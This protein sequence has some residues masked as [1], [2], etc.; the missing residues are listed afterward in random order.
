MKKSDI[1]SRF[2]EMNKTDPKYLKD[3]ILSFIIAGKDTTA[4][5]LSWFFYMMCKHPFLQE[6]IAEEVSKATGINQNS[7]IDELVN[8]INDDALDKMQYLH[9]SLT[10]TL[11]LYPAIPLVILIYSENDMIFTNMDLIRPGAGLHSPKGGQNTLRR[12]TFSNI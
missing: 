6:K 9:A 2:L 8:S 5:T 12:K 4:S 1:L 11:R 7:S 3:I 10:E